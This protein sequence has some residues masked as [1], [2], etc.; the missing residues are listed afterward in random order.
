MKSFFKR[1]ISCLIVIVSLFA[2]ATFNHVVNAEDTSCQYDFTKISSFSTWNN[3]YSARNFTMTANG[4]TV[5]FVFSAASKQTQTITNCPVTKS[6]NLVISL[7]QADIDAGYYISAYTINF[8]QWNTKTQKVKVEG[9][10]NGSTYT[11]VSNETS[12]SFSSSAATVSKN[13]TEKT[14]KY[15]KVSATQGNQ[16]GWAG[17]TL[18][19]SKDEDATSADKFSQLETLA[20]LNLNWTSQEVESSSVETWELVTDV[21]TL[22]ENDEVIIAAKD[23]NYAISTTQNSNNRAQASISK[24]G[25]IVEFESG[26]QV[27]TLKTGKVANTFA[28]YTGSGYLFAAS[29]SSNY[30]KTETTLSNNSSWNITIAATGVATIVAKGTNTR[31]TM[32]YN[33]SSALF[34]AYSSDS[35]K[36]VCIYKK[37]VSSGFETQYNLV[38]G[39]VALRFGA[40]VPAEIFE[41]LSAQGYTFGVNV[42]YNGKTKDVICE[43]VAEVTVDEK[44]YYQFS[45]VIKNIPASAYK[46]TFTAVCYTELN[47]DRATMIE[48][49]HSVASILKAYTE[50]ASTSNGNYANLDK[51]VM[52]GLFETANK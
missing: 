50:M 5:S 14:Y 29:S 37:V 16:V 13:L 46:D 32:Q 35:Q 21:N 48:K 12:L 42:T 45:A 22:S 11:V 6:G 30:L 28:F 43:N 2:I 4:H 34:A 39:T 7:S 40:L 31:N 33:Q 20:S 15:L 51:D 47:G 3:S 49:T 1:I 36:A 19:I 10:P 8:K 17:V 27:F 23:Y 26:V 52:N 44:E 38:E 9:S 18:V 41:D 25:S 24:N